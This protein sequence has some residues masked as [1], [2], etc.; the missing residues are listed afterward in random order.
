MPVAM[1]CVIVRDYQQGRGTSPNIS[2][3]TLS[4]ALRSERFVLV[5][6]VMFT[7]SENFV[8]STRHHNIR[9]NGILRALFKY[10]IL[11]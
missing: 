8:I 9:Q 7:E 6:G 10:V 5:V 3:K 11:I 4:M 2:G 1:C